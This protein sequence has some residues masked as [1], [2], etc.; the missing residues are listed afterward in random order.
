M[1]DADPAVPSWPERTASPGL[2]RR[3]A[4]GGPGAYRG[5]NGRRGVSPA[6]GAVNE[7]MRAIA[8]IDARLLGHGDTVRAHDRMRHPLTGA[9]RRDRIASGDRWRLFGRGRELC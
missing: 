9:K 7:D 2:W 3:H 1:N 6:S 8:M 5:G 4:L